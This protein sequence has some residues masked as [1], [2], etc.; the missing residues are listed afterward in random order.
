ME[1]LQQ[2]TNTEHCEVWLRAPLPGIL[3]AD[4][5]KHDLV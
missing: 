3:P 1:D 4:R 5:H 2:H